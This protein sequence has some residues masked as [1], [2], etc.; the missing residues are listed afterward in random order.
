MTGELKRD[1]NEAWR[2]ELMLPLQYRIV[3]FLQVSLGFLLGLFAW[4]NLSRVYLQLGREFPINDYLW[5][6]LSTLIGALSFLSLSKLFIKKFGDSRVRLIAAS[7]L[8]S[9]GGTAF[10]NFSTA[11][12]LS[13][14]GGES[15]IYFISDSGFWILVEDTVLLLILGALAGATIGFSGIL[16]AAIL[17]RKPLP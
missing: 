2:S 7:A 14:L 12:T 5:F 17:W 3:I 9:A 8:V 16:F 1:H 4:W 15:S 13:L 11:L 10:T 6:T